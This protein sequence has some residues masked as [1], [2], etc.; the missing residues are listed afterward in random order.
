MIPKVKTYRGIQVV[1]D[2][3]Y[4]G[5]TKA[6][7]FKK[8]YKE[9]IEIVYACSPISCTQIAL[10][11]AAKQAGGVATI[12][13]AKRGK[14][15]VQTIEALRLGAEIHECYPGYL[16]VA[17]ARAMEFA[18]ENECYYSPLG[19]D[20]PENIK[21]I[22]LLARML[23]VEPDEVW[24]AAGSGVLTRALQMAWPDAEHHAVQVGGKCDIGKAKR[25]EHPDKFD[26]PCSR[27]PPFPSEEYYDAKAWE[28]LMEQVGPQPM[29]R[30]VLFWNCLG[31]FNRIV[32]AI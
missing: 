18:K 32:R 10:A 7:L 29:G 16:T 5:G 28:I 12:F 15:T 13:T 23:D 21:E 19:F 17:K 27:Q 9:N 26:K 4:P 31:N 20:T 25:H 22:A 8:L 11:R 14:R 30:S 3:L 6:R 2:D 24:C 1:R